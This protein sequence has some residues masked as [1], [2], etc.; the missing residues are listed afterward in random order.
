[1]HCSLN[2]IENYQSISSFLTGRLVTNLEAYNLIQI[3]IDRN[4]NTIIVHRNKS[5][6]VFQ[7]QYD[8]LNRSLHSE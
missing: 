8:I 4:L 6:S 7:T 1:M 5:R 3:D 2:G